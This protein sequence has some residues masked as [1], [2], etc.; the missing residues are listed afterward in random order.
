MTIINT[1][2]LLL[3]VFSPNNSAVRTAVCTCSLS[4]TQLVQITSAEQSHYIVTLVNIRVT[5]SQAESL[6]HLMVTNTIIY[7]RNIYLQMRFIISDILILYSSLS[8]TVS[9]FLDGSNNKM[10][11]NMAFKLLSINCKIKYKDAGSRADLNK[12]NIYRRSDCW[13]AFLHKFQSNDYSID[14]ISN[15]YFTQNKSNLP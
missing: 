11:V 3:H 1:A 15:M 8:F 2:T 14:K 12:N 4:W 6:T 13:Y 9:V 7:N 5:E 10:T